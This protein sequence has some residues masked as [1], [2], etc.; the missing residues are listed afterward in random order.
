MSSVTD[1][2]ATINALVDFIR[3]YFVRIVTTAA[4]SASLF[5][6]LIVLLAL[7]TKESR[8]RVAFRLN[9]FA[10][11]I[12]LTM[13]VLVA[14]CDAK[15]IMLDMPPASVTLHLLKILAFPCYVKCA[16][17]VALTLFL[18]DYYFASPTPDLV[19]RNPNL[20]V[21]FTMQITDN[22]YSVGFFLYNLHVR[23]RSMKRGGIPARV[24]QIFYISVANFV[25]PLILSIALLITFV[26]AAPF[27]I[28]WYLLPV[29]NNY[30]TVMGS[31]SQRTIIERRVRAQTEL[32]KG[33]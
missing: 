30:V 28:I 3:P 13:D 19:F 1:P 6:L 27:H 14:F 33:T 10:I 26:A 2:E 16:R 8:R 25:F 15:T 22:M 7:S 29:V 32:A 31:E 24:R 11:C 23:T 20:I 12:A 21:E 5:T 9:V 18:H 17:V 4:F